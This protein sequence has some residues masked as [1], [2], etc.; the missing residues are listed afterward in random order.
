MTYRQYLVSIQIF[1]YFRNRLQ[2]LVNLFNGVPRI[3][4]NSFFTS[5]ELHYSNLTHN[6]NGY[7]S[8][9]QRNNLI[10]TDIRPNL[11][12]HQKSEQYKLLK[13]V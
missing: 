11:I 1:L 13:L 8:N 12:L 10:T 9:T 4:P 3:L 7:S 5:N 2:C 6:F